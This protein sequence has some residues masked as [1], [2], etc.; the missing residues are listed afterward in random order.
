MSF[1]LSVAV[2]FLIAAPAA[3][4][5]SS[6]T[7]VTEAEWNENSQR[8]EIAMKLRIADLQDAISAKQGKRMRLHTGSPAAAI[9]EY[10]T[11]NFCVTFTENQECRLRW[12]GMELE[13]HDVWLYFEAEPVAEGRNTAFFSEQNAGQSA[14]P[15]KVG[16][17][18]ELFVR[19]DGAKSRFETTG[20]FGERTVRVRDTVLCDIQPD[21]TNLVT[22]RVAGVTQS[23]IFEHDHTSATTKSA[24]ALH[25]QNSTQR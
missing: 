5:H 16:T 25:S 7:S 24:N 10:L 6:H 15:Q 20:R 18:N 14:M 12:V 22:I 2:L 11:E 4:A 8:F 3:E 23:L 21:Q 17:W 19:H 13:L 9:L 1:R